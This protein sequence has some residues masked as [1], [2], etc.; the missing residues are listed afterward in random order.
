M[1]CLLAIVLISLAWGFCN[2]AASGTPASLSADGAHATDTDGSGGNDV[3]EHPGKTVPAGGVGLWES[4]TGDTLLYADAGDTLRIDIHVN[5]GD[6]QANGFQL[7]VTFDTTYLA[8]LD[9]DKAAGLQPFIPGGLVPESSVFQL[10]DTPDS[11]AAVHLYYAEVSLGG[12]VTDTGMLAGLQLRVL[13]PIPAG[14]SIPV[15]VENDTLNLRRSFYTISGPSGSTYAL[16]PRNRIW[17]RNRPPGLLTPEQLTVPEDSTLVLILDTFVQD[18]AFSAAEMA[19][20]VSV[21]DSGFGVRIEAVEGVQRAAVTPPS[22]WNGATR[23]AFQVTDPE[24]LSVSMTSDLTVTPVNDPPVFSGLLKRGI[25]TDEDRTF[26]AALDSLVS[27]VDDATS[28]LEW[29]VESGKSVSAGIDPESGLLRVVPPADWNGADTVEVSVSDV[30]GAFARVSVPVYV[31]AVNDPPKFLTPLPQLQSAGG[32]TALDLAAF[33]ADVDDSLSTLAWRVDGAREL[34][35]RIDPDGY[36]HVTSPP[37]WSGAEA[38]MVTVEDPQGASASVTLHLRAAISGDFD[39]GGDVGF[40]DFILFVREFGTSEGGPDF[41]PLFDL[42]DNGRVDFADFV[43]F[44][45]V[46]GTGG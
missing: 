13:Q 2:G 25:H 17:I 18:R 22:D 5:V 35:V 27:D 41:D 28:E 20:S 44:A 9:Q 24:G 7:F 11:S 3:P 14:E 43:L 10:L 38:L 36:L 19:W 33:A 23:I 6:D 46:Y 32:D 30:A 37:G 34:D 40:S 31:R 45:A 4:A 12:T 16:T 21:A 1:R 15:A 39:G 42:S 26:T 29:A 8:P